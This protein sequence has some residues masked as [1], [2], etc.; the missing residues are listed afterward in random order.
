MNFSDVV[1]NQY[2]E[3]P[4]REYLNTLFLIK[5]IGRRG[6]LEWLARSPDLSPIDFYSLKHRITAEMLSIT[7][8]MFENARNDF[9]DRLGN[10]QEV[11]GVCFEHFIN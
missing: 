8:Q 11:E 7:P 9:C 4:V 3:V 2:S 5:W 6:A 1:Q 10:C